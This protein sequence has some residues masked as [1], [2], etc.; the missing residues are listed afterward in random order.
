[1]PKRGKIFLGGISPATTKESIEA[2]FGQYGHIIDA[3]AMMQ[4]GKPRGFGFVTFEDPQIA[5][6]VLAVAHELDGHAI[7]LKAAVPKNEEPQ[8]GQ[9]PF[10]VQPV[11]QPMMPAPSMAPQYSSPPKGGGKGKAGYEGLT[12]KVFIGGLAPALTDD[13]FISYF[14]PYGNIVDS[15]VMKDKMTGKPKGFGFVQFD[16]TESVELVMKDYETHAL[17]GKWIEVKRAVPKDRMAASQ[18]PQSFG[19]MGGGGG[20]GKAQPLYIS[21]HDQQG[22]MDNGFYNFGGSPQA[23]Y[24]KGGYGGCGGGMAGCGMAGGGGCGGY[25]QGMGGGGKGG[26]QPFRGKPY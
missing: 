20:Y 1:M 6:E 10:N 12:D 17:H 3:V 8:F 2:Y 18:A 11:Y 23:A 13:E 14:S 19:G 21:V 25:V 15:V 5:D 7:E 4:N 22:G 9:V 24:A 16:N 26:Y